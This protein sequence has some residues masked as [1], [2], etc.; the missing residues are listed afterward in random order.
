MK[1]SKAINPHLIQFN[2]GG[3]EKRDVI[4]RVV[5]LLAENDV[6]INADKYLEDVLAREAQST[7]GIG[8]GIAIPHAKSEGVKETCF[9]LVRLENEVEWESLDDQPVRYVIMLAV[10]ESAKKD[11][12]KLLSQL[13]TLLME[14]DFREGLLVAQT[15]HEIVD[16]FEKEEEK[17]CTF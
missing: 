5:Q 9:T 12:L 10:P 17:L 2:L 11:F 1:L 6:L 15:T 7:T 16:L 13:S 8:M 3:R 14:E 4:E